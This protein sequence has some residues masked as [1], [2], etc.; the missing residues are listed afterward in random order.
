VSASPANRT[1]A[2]KKSSAKKK[3]KYDLRCIWP[4]YDMYSK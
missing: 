4:P 1:T 3:D 2:V